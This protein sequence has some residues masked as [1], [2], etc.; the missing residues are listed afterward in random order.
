MSLVGQVDWY[1]QVTV[2]ARETCGMATAA[3]PVAPAV[4][5]N[6]RRV[7]DFALLDLLVDMGVA[8][9]G[10]CDGSAELLRWA[11]LR[12]NRC[13]AGLFPRPWS[14]VEQRRKYST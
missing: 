9:P 1:F 5:R 4:S 13:S 6:L 12:T 10:E 11:A 8:L 7:A 2:C 3:A 14:Y